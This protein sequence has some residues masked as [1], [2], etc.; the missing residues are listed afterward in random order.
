MCLDES[1][2]QAKQTMEQSFGKNASFSAFAKGTG[3]LYCIH[4]VPSSPGSV[5]R[6]K[7]NQGKMEFEKQQVS[8]FT[9]FRDLGLNNEDTFIF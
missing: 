2:G 3:N 5:S 8:N 7:F 1:N 4:E 6:W 9:K